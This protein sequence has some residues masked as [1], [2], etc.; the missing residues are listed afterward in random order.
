MTGDRLLELIGYRVALDTN[1]LL[2]FLTGDPVRGPLM[3][4]VL[5]LAVDGA[6]EAVIPAIVKLE[7]MV[8]ALRSEDARELH[9]VM[10]LTEGVE[11]VGSAEIDADT[12]AIGAEVRARSNLKTPDA[13]VVATAITSGCSAILGNDRAMRRVD[14]LR[15]AGELVSLRRRPVPRFLRIDDLIVH[16]R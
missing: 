10:E 1:G 13:L 4:E 2:Y 14:L 7:L 6:I 9:R 15:E 12:I 5:T 11:N 16:E 8:G 3:R